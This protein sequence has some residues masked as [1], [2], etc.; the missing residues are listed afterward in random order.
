MKG[1]TVKLVL[2]YGLDFDWWRYG[3]GE[4]QQ[5]QG[6]QESE[7]GDL[8]G[9]RDFPTLEIKK[10]PSQSAVTGSQDPYSQLSN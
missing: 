10:Y 5:G 8:N 6:H 9:L 3:V 4:G 1:V 7:M 2:K